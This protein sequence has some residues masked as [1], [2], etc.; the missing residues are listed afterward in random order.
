MTREEKNE[1]NP[2]LKILLMSLMFILLF[3]TVVS[4]DELN[5]VN[6]PENT[7]S[8]LKVGNGLTIEKFSDGRVKGIENAKSLN[9]LQKKEIL[10][11]MK[12]TTEEIE[13]LPSTLINE[14]ISEG[15]VKVQ[16]EQKNYKHI[17]TSLDGMDYIV[18]D[19]T[20]ELVDK[21]K[22]ADAVKL[23]LG[24]NLIGTLEMGGHSE[25]IFSGYG[26]L[27][28]NGK[29]S[30]NQEYKYSFVT[31]FNWS[32]GPTAWNYDKVAVA[33]ETMATRTGSTGH[34]YL[35]G[36]SSNDI[37][38]NISNSSVYG[39]EGTT[40]APTYNSYGYLMVNV[41]LPVSED[42]NSGIF[43]SGYGHSWTPV[44]ISVTFGP[45]GVDFGGIG[46]KWDWDNYFTIGKAY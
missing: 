15:G 5:S 3:S 12:F 32:T 30:N 6:N 34:H 42:G 45:I 21:V 10:K 18:T 9:E 44:P 39:V 26:T 25:G 38:M 7:T 11:Q 41:N 13:K 23:G 35:Y 29:T 36:N 19:E 2:V 8:K 16:L 17:Y 40:Q 27:I 1:K 14:I 24:S 43:V 28:F 22:A 33:Y 4:A 37:G 31:N 46:D 20:K